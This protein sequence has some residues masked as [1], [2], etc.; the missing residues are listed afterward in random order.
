MDLFE[1]MRDLDLRQ[2]AKD[3]LEANEETIA[4]LNATQMAAG[5]RSDGTEIL[6]SYADLTILLKS[7]KA[8]LSGVSDHVTLYDEGDHYRELYADVVGD[9]LEVGSRDEKSDD[10]DFKYSTQRGS[11]YGLNEDSREELV[12]SRLRGD[13]LELIH[14][15][16][17]L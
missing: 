11:I 16:T 4:D 8:G 10:L 17:G 3:A 14:E 7:E 12:E 9:E 13:F 6:P 1:N 5:L 2:K 15:H